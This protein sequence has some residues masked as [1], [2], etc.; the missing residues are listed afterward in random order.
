LRQNR[1]AFRAKGQMNTSTKTNNCEV[2]FGELTYTVATK[3]VIISALAALLISTS[4]TPKHAG[5]VVFPTRTFFAAENGSFPQLKSFGVHESDVS[6]VS[7]IENAKRNYESSDEE[8]SDAEFMQTAYRLATSSKSAKKGKR[9]IQKGKG[10][11]AV[12]GSKAWSPAAS[13]G[14]H[15]QDLGH[16]FSLY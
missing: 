9:K 11:R 8:S 5:Y 2:K 15:F 7:A 16:S 10:Q 6:R 13:L 1:H 4:I 14:Q 3:N 12:Q